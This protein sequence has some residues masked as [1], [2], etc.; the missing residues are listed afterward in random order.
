MEYHSVRMYAREPEQVP[1][2]VLGFAA[3]DQKQIRK[4]VRNWAQEFN[5]R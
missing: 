5:Q 3:F 2:M 1:G 4:A